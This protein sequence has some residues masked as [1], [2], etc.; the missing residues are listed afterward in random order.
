M[1]LRA[2]LAFSVSA[3]LAVFAT[4]GAFAGAP[5]GFAGTFG[6]EY[7]HAS[8]SGGGG[9]ENAW[10]AN[11]SGAF[12][13]GA[14]DLAAEIDGGYHNI[15]GGGANE[16]IWN[17][18]GHLFWAPAMGRVGAS[19]GY[20][21]LDTSGINA[22]VT[23]YGGFGEY[24]A[25]D[26]ITL[27]IRGGGLSA[28][29]SFSG[30]SGSETGSYIGGGLTGYLVPDLALT[31]VINYDTISSLHFTTYGGTAEYMF[32]DMMP[33]AIYGGYARVDISSGGG[34]VDQWLIGVKFYTN[35]NGTTLVERQ[36]N[37]A[38]GLLSAGSSLEFAF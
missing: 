23:T 35:G 22:H 37:G 25:S 19:V 36:R 31:G 17:V 29:A 33:L 32:S 16:D 34:H 3:A 11:G 7:A 15:T 4:S 28:S 12:G 14:N 27:G 9:D 18:A 8:A 20:V 38:L 6:G 30:L 1:A 10:S 21:S 5:I 24:Y 26:A 2:Q 13:F